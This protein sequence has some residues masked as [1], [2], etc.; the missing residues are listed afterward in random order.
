M[1]SLLP[2]RLV[3]TPSY[4]ERAYNPFKGIILYLIIGR[5]YMNLFGSN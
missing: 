5:R 2:Y 4:P 1:D 3:I